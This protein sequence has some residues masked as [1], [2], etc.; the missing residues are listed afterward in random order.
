MHSYG[1][2]HAMQRLKKGD[3]LYRPTPV[4]NAQLYNER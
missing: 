1:K 2:I 4:A 3:D